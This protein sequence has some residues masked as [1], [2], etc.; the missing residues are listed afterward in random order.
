MPRQPIIRLQVRLY[1]PFRKRAWPD[2]ALGV[3]LHGLTAIAVA[4]LLLKLG[5]MLAGSSWQQGPEGK[6]V[7]PILWFLAAPLSGLFLRMYRTRVFGRATIGTDQLRIQVSGRPRQRLTTRQLRRIRLEAYEPGDRAVMSPGGRLF[8]APGMMRALPTTTSGLTKAYEPSLNTLHFESLDSQGR[9]QPE[10]ALRFWL[11][12]PRDYRKLQSIVA[13]WRE[14]G[15]GVD[16]GETN[17]PHASQRI[18][19][20]ETRPEER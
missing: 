15:I 3:A 5:G 4:G 19:L 7:F 1:L 2:Q 17:A 10:R 14:Q 16:D 9:P 6:P 8:P 12:H 13:S 18:V 20:E 11:D